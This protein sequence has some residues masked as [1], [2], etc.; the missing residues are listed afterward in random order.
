MGI[1][2]VFKNSLNARL[3]HGIHTGQAGRGFFFFY[4][5]LAHDH[6]LQLEP[7]L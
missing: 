1:G 5:L 2:H 4:C 6:H 7:M 3:A